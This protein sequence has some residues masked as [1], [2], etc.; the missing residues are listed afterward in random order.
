[1]LSVKSFK[2]SPSFFGDWRHQL[3]IL[4]S[5]SFFGDWWH[6]LK[7]LKSPHRFSAIGG[8]S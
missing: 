7:V 4:K 5:P 8:I 3:K 2:K 6:Q 1:M